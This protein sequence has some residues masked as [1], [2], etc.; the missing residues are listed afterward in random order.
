MPR[1]SGYV[2][3]KWSKSA[4]PNAE[5]K[6]NDT[7]MTKS[8]EK[9]WFTFEIGTGTYELTVSKVMYEDSK[10]TITFIGESTINIIIK[11]VMRAL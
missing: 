1:I 7:L 8:D 4:V 6:I 3:E 5:I 9:G 11:P 10:Q 2:I